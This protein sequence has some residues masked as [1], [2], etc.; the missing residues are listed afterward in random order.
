MKINPIFKREIMVSSRSKSLPALICGVN[1]L[2]FAVTLIGASGV[3]T[4]MEVSAESDYSSFLRIYGL[5]VLLE[6]LL[7]LFITPSLTAGAISSERERE[8]FDL[9]LTTQMKP[10]EI[11]SGKLMSNLSFIIVLEISCIPAVLVALIYGGVTVREI[12]ELL[13]IYTLE[14]FVFMSAGMFFSSVSKSTARASAFTYGFLVFLCFGTAVISML[15]AV[16]SGGGN[17][18]SLV[19]LLIN[20][21][22]NVA[23][24]V[25]GQMGE[26]AML[27]EAASRVFAGYHSGLISFWSIISTLSQLTMAVIM[28][29]ASV[30]N[31]S[32]RRKIRKELDFE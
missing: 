13:V 10:S 9:M 29:I 28:I 3:V 5:V 8:T 6:F 18:F 12:A 30:I 14:A 4:A 23:N 25:A 27:S 24:I 17:V 11:V 21:L 2:L 26:T 1:I 32:P 22:I 16:I 19:I 20:P 7:L 31:I 15:L